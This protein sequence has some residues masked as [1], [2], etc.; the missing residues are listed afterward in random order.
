MVK[1][2]YGSDLPWESCFSI[3]V[4]LSYF[5]IDKAEARNWDSA[6]S[7]CPDF[8]RFGCQLKLVVQLLIFTPELEGT[9][10][11]CFT[12]LPPEPKGLGKPVKWRGFLCELLG[13]QSYTFGTSCPG[14]SEGLT[15]WL[16]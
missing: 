11:L 9:F 2:R 7:F 14:D 6:H 15:S 8:Q 4:L 16:G 10:S 5:H 12:Q 3:C 1:S 13:P